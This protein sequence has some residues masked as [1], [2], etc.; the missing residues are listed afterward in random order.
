MKNLRNFR[1][2]I[3][4]KADVMDGWIMGH[5]IPAMC[6]A[7]LLAF[8]SLI[9]TA[10]FPVY[11][12]G[13][14]V[15]IALA[16]LS[17]EF[18]SINRAPERR[19]HRAIGLLG[20]NLDPGPLLG[21]AQSQLCKKDANRPGKKQ[22]LLDCL[23]I[24]QVNSGMHQEAVNTFTQLQKGGDPQIKGYAKFMCASSR[25]LLHLNAGHSSGA[26]AEI[27]KAEELLRDS[28]MPE[29]FRSARA[30]G[31]RLMK[32]RSR[33]LQRDLGGIEGALRELLGRYGKDVTKQLE[34][35]FCLGLYYQAAENFGQARSEFDFVCSNGGRL[36]LADDARER[37]GILA[38]ISAAL[39]SGTGIVL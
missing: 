10:F 4:K 5:R 25:V 13:L 12:K 21:E 29:T 2:T 14:P 22:M 35:R 15:L 27:K 36:Y 24:A 28:T 1:E 6:C 17:L 23:A 7:A 8:S 19:L 26:D 32:I 9:L 33:I 11:A 39:P 37:L 20:S 16:L 38:N 31:L 30:E 18:A 3:L 34:I